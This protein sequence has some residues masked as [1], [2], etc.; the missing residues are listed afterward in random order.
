MTGRGLLAGLWGLAAGCAAAA[1]AVAVELA[2]GGAVPPVA[3]PSEPPGPP[4][5]YEWPVVRAI[6]GATLLVDA[7]AD[8]PPEL[9]ML[10]VQV[11]PPAGWVARFLGPDMVSEVLAGA[12]VVIRNPRWGGPDDSG[13]VVADVIVDGENL[14]AALAQVLEAYSEGLPA[15][16]Y[17]WPVVEIIDGATLVVDA[18]A[19]LPPDLSRLTVRVGGLGGGGTF[20]LEG[21]DFVSR[22]L[23]AASEVV[24][25]NPQFGRPDCECQVVADVLIDGEDLL[26]LSLAE[27]PDR[28]RPR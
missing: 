19:D 28:R 13:R 7:G 5:D 6:D 15:A 14:S 26:V 1:D 3:S 21:A 17:E 11:R 2:P 16:D 4:V 12:A 18:S 27:W 25:R 22:R 20:Q 8:L 23:A 9:A 10:T 24:I